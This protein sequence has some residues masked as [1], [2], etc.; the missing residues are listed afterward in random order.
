MTIATFAGRLTRIFGFGT[1]A[2]G[3]NYQRKSSVI[4]D[5]A[6]TVWTQPKRDGAAQPNWKA[7][8]LRI[9]NRDAK[10]ASI[11]E[12]KHIILSEGRK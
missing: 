12:R 9:Y 5:P 7:R 2:S 1:P 8:A 6:E 3:Q 10:R 4:C 11:Y